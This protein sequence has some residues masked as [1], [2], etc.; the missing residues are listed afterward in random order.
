MNHLDHSGL[1]SGFCLLNLT[2]THTLSHLHSVRVACVYACVHAQDRTGRHDRTG[3]D[4]QTDI[5]T[6]RQTDRQ[7]DR[8]DIQTDI[9]THRQTDI[10]RQTQTD[11]YRHIQT[12]TDTHITLNNVRICTP[13]TRLPPLRCHTHTSHTRTHT[14]TDILQGLRRMLSHA[15]MLV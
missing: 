2:H 6:D 14:H 10:H 4:R 15:S 8:T 3:Q 9:Q 11:T 7:T 12:Q 1:E 5:H 13:H